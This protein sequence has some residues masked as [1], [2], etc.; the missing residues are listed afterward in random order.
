VADLLSAAS[1]FNLAQQ[2]NLNEIQ[3]RAYDQLRNDIVFGFTES[4]GFV[5]G[6]NDVQQVRLASANADIGEVR[7]TLQAT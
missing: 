6:K 5:V 3:K 4:P 7:V 2:K 1:E